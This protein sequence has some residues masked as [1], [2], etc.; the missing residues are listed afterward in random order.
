MNE[1]DKGGRRALFMKQHG[2]ER[3]S[4]GSSEQH[5]ADARGMSGEGM[6]RERGA[7]SAAT[8]PHS[9]A[10]HATSVTLAQSYH[11]RASKRSAD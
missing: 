5:N 4:R 8:G 7:S 11:G 9:L 10:P 6:A 3:R 1:G 2:I